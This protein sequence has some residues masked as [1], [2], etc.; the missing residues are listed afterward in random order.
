M[1]IQIVTQSIQRSHTDS[2][3]SSM[4]LN[5]LVNLGN[6]MGDIKYTGSCINAKIHHA[7]LVNGIFN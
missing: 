1:L 7:N 3:Y 6:N 4:K 5:D 2:S